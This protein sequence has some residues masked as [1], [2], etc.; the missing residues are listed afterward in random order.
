[1]AQADKDDRTEAPSAK[2]LSKAREDGRVAV[3]RELQSLCGLGFGVLALMIVLPSQA[4]LFAA[5]MQGLM[6]NVGRIDVSGGGAI[7]AWRTAMGFCPALAA[8]V[9]LAASVGAIAVG[10]LQTGFLLHLGSLMPKPGR[11][12][13]GRG[14]KRLF[15]GETLVEGL[16]SLAKLAAFGFVLWHVFGGLLITLPRAVAW[17]P[18]A[19]A[20]QMLALT[21]KAALLV[22]AVQAGI[23]LLDVVWVRYKHYAELRMSRQELRDEHRESEGDPQVKGRLR[24]LRRQ[25]AAR[26]MMAAVPKATVV[27]T[28]P[29]H[30]A[31]AL[32]YEGGS[33]AAPRIVAKGMD[34]LAARIREVAQ[35]NK[36]P[37]VSNPPL[38][39]ALYTLPLDSEVPREHFQVVAGIIAYVWRLRR[40]PPG[41]P[42]VR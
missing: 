30:Y 27:I 31:V 22:L 38:A 18:A 26:R 15:G 16:K 34:E 4:A 39:R 20:S 32:A 36:V 25:R 10:L 37:L 3:S 24:Q 9:L 41:G 7:A 19:L 13:P 33:K 21:L 35:D 6:E 29:T 14:I 28:N 11:L 1:M 23:A 2:A 40:P 5:R 42:P 17:R 8:P 12:N